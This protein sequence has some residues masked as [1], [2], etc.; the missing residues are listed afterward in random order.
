LETK[1]V[2]YLASLLNYL[3]RANANDKTA[4]V[5]LEKAKNHNGKAYQTLKS[6]VDTAITSLSGSSPLPNTNE[7][8]AGKTKAE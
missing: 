5:G 3:Q 4:L 1:D 7:K 8:I 6:R 2:Y